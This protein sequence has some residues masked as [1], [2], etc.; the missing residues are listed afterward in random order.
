M[1][2]NKLNP[3][4]SAL[5]VIDIQEKLFPAISNKEEILENIKIL[6]ES[7]KLL[8][9]K[10]LVTEQYPRGLGSTIPE[11]QD[12]ISDMNRAEK[13]SF[14][15][16]DDN[17]AEIQKL[18]NDG[19]ENFILCGI[20]SHICVYQTAKNLLQ[21]GLNVFVVYDATG[22]RKP[23]NHSHILDTLLSMGALIVPTETVVFELLS[24]AKH[25]NFK[26]ISKL[27]K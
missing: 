25:K 1:K 17:S 10:T 3:T 18:I 7:A 4:N 27:V 6:L 22:S 21:K 11:L 5:L 8:D 20:E 13:T 12:L 9:V 16:C 26:D 14:S 2:L 19:V 24:T 23:S 15:I